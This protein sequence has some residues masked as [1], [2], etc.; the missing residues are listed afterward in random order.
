[1]INKRGFTLVELIAVISI[2][3]L[4]M[5]LAATS[6]T[7]TL[8]ESRENLLQEQIKSLKDTAITYVSNKKYYFKVCPD[9]FN[10]VRTTSKD[11]NCYVKL[12][13]SELIQ[14]GLFENTITFLSILNE[15]GAVQYG[16]LKA[17]FIQCSF[18]IPMYSLPPAKFTALTNFFPLFL[19]KSAA[20]S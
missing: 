20:I 9:T 16:I 6:I 14:S 4:L 15:Y 11:K 7:K 12:T 13:V 3:G 10:P 1:M 17:F 8:N 5:T 2:L 18:M 19:R